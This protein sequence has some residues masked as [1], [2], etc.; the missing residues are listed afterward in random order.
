MKPQKFNP[1]D[2]AAV[3]KKMYKANDLG[4]SLPKQ[5]DLVTINKYQYYS[6]AFRVWIVTIVGYPKQ[7]FGEDIFSPVMSQHVLESELAEV[8]K[9]EAKV[10]Q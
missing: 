5:N 8:E 6:H 3:V 4:L 10:W 1:G 9:L 7:D 2:E